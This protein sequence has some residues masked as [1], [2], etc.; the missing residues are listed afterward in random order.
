MF[1]VLLLAACVEVA[2]AFWPEDLKAW[3]CVLF[4]GVPGNLNLTPDFYQRGGTEHPGRLYLHRRRHFWGGREGGG[5]TNSLGGKPLPFTKVVDR[6]KCS[7]ASTEIALAP[8]SLFL[9]TLCVH[10]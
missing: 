4:L 1:V 2:V 7:A 9:N 5:S 6:R 3:S 10:I 8:L